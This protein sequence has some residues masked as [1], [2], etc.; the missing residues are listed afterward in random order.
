L[1]HQKPGSLFGASGST[2]YIVESPEARVTIW[3]FWIY[4]LY[5]R[6]NDCLANKYYHKNNTETE[7]VYLFYHY[8]VHLAVNV[9]ISIIFLLMWH[10]YIAVSTDNS[11]P[12]AN[13]GMTG[14]NVAVDGSL[15]TGRYALPCDWM[16]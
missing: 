9:V 14:A 5:L 11:E 3:S 1:S 15:A 13:F 8:F 4:I 6:R 2:F 16:I 10:Q 7:I 12:D